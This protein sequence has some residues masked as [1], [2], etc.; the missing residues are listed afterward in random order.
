MN[1][2]NRLIR[3]VAILTAIVA[4][5][6]I[7]YMTIEGWSFLDALYMTIT[8]ITTVGYDEVH[9]LSEAGKVFS[10][11]LIVGGVGGALYALT[12]AVG[13]FVE[14]RFGST[15]GRRQMKNKIARLKDHFIICGYGRVGQEVARAFAGDGVPFVVIDSNPES[16]AQA[17]KDGYPYLQAN[18]TED[19]VLKE[20]GI[21]KARGLVAAVGGDVDNTYITLSARGLRPDLFIAVRASDREAEVKLARAGA[22]RI[23]SPYSI[24]ARRLAM[25][26]LRPAVV[27]FIDTVSYGPGRE[28]K[29]EN[30][31]VSDG[32]SL[33]GTTVAATRQRTKVNILAISD[34]KGKLL[35]NPAGED[36][37]E[38]GG[39]L[40]VIGTKEQLCALEKG[41]RNS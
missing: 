38:A 5:G 17:E 7:G 26:A 25:L 3:V 13:Y 31:A 2:H 15:L 4:G 32:S 22:D 18:A 36:M 16:I 23:V 27:D 19:D 30:I 12:T 14:G 37:I 41:C 29:L 33:A 24:G 1:L 11:I 6:T 28:L 40:I 35:A 20:A 9:P 8:T 39:R 21:E 34:K 10:I